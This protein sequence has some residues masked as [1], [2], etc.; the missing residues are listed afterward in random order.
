MF[1]GFYFWKLPLPGAFFGTWHD[2]VSLIIQ[3]RSYL[4]FQSPS[5]FGHK[6]TLYNPEPKK[7]FKISKVCELQRLWQSDQKRVNRLGLIYFH[8]HLLIEPFQFQSW[9]LKYSYMR[10]LFTPSESIN[11][12]VNVTETVDPLIEIDFIS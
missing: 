1:N 12:T 10:L 4:Q 5:R 11:S 6:T 9:K 8:I 7:N 3:R 2:F